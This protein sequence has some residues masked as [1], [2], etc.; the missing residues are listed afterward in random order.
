VAHA[1]RLSFLGAARTVTGSC[2]LLDYAGGQVLIDCGLF[3]GSKSLKALN[4]GAFSFDPAQLAAVLVTHAHID[5]SGLLP[6]LARDGYRGR[7][8]TT[9]G[10]RDLLTYMLPDSGYIQESE[11]EQ[12]NRR[13]RQRGEAPVVPIYTQAVAEATLDQIDAVAFGEW[14]DPVAGLRARFWKAG[15]ILGASSIELEI[16]SGSGDDPVRILFSGDLGGNESTLHQPPDAP[17]GLDYLVVEATYG[18]RDRPRL[19]LEQRRENLA[20][21]VST[22]LAA[23][24]NLII[25]AFAVERTQELLLDLGRLF[26]TRRLPESPVF[27]DSPL[28]IR[29]T[30][31]FRDHAGELGQAAA[32]ADPFGGRIF[33]FTE[34]VAESKKLNLI[35][36]G[37]IIM[38]ASGMC[39]A[40]RIRHHLKNNLWRS[41]ATVL[42][43]GYQAPGTLGHL[44]LSGVPA[45]RIQGEEVR[46][47][48]RIRHLE[49]YSAHADRS[50]LLRW[51]T[52][53]MPIRS[54]ILAT[55][56]EPESIAGLQTAL[57]D[58]LTD[59]PPILAPTLDSYLALDRAAPRLEQ[60][61]ARLVE[62]GAARHDW[63]NDYASF[64]LDLGERLRSAPNEASRRNMLSRLSDALR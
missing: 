32:E 15:H 62:E 60:N 12:L 38:A 18:N 8:L 44:L 19:T 33:H 27:L 20:E 31:V 42:L 23:G 3:Q 37:A 2:Y 26:A 52:A 55:H 11:V 54:A 24:G 45:V 46:V 21:E 36:S 50:E 49:T 58:H 9:A 10:S 29:A 35:R 34:D 41:D 51:V 28:A 14:V 39:D 43:V 40:G 5:H 17:S 63:H 6:K 53:R 61:G 25:P 59:P 1:A 47:R 7:I 56:G 57:R 22:A 13:R 48:A 4:Y 30:E 64:L 16:A